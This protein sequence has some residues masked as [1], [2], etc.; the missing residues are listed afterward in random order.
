MNVERLHYASD[1][2][3]TQFSFSRH[4]LLPVHSTNLTPSHDE[5][6]ACRP[7]PSLAVRWDASISTAIAHL[8][9]PLALRRRIAW[10]G[11]RLGR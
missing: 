1:V 7:R 8:T 4:F 11:V 9:Y 6:P 3:G 10:L 2:L 5:L